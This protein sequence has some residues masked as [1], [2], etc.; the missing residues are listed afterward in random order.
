M[1][2]SGVDL[3]RL[4]GLQLRYWCLEMDWSGCLASPSKAAL[5]ISASVDQKLLSVL[6]LGE[7]LNI[8]GLIIDTH[9]PRQEVVA[10]SR[11]AFWSQTKQ[12]DAWNSYNQVTVRNTQITHP[13]PGGASSDSRWILLPVGFI[14][15]PIDHDSE[16]GDVL[17]PSHKLSATAAM[18][19]LP[20]GG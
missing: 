9:S 19:L 2:E 13:I 18:Q 5:R 7:G 12:P 8:I 6:V 15:Q 20:G 11:R 3:P 4:M 10:A 17:A 1:H 16:D 14:D